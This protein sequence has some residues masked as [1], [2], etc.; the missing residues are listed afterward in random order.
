MSSLCFFSFRSFFRSIIARL[1]TGSPCSFEFAATR[2]ARLRIPRTTPTKSVLP[3]LRRWPRLPRTRSEWIPTRTR[4]LRRR[5]RSL[6]SRKVRF[7]SLTVFQPSFSLLLDADQTLVP[8]FFIQH[9]P[10]RLRLSRNPSLR[11]LLLFPT[12]IRMMVSRRVLSAFPPPLPLRPRPDSYS[13]S[14]SSH[15][16]YQGEAGLQAQG[17]ASCFG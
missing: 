13:S 16:A 1:L 8:S 15:Q 17:E 2:R 10:S 11:L 9:H 3:N 5:R 14:I 12:R 7:V 4:S 6:T